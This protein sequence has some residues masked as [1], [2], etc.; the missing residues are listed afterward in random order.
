MRTDTVTPLPASS[1]PLIS[2]AVLALFATAPRSRPVRVGVSCAGG[3]HRN[4]VVA[5]AV[6]PRPSF[7]RPPRCWTTWRQ[8]LVPAS[9]TQK[10][11]QRATLAA[12]REATRTASHAEVAAAIGVS[13]S[14]VNKAITQHNAAARA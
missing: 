9:R 13:P 7:P 8:S 1:S 3:R 6:A 10:R 4:V 11:A 14:A 5:E 2:A 12:V